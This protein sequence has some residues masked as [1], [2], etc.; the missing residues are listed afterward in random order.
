MSFHSVTINFD[1]KHG[2][3]KL[4]N[5]GHKKCVLVPMQR[6]MIVKCGRRFL[7][8][9]T[10]VDVFRISIVNTVT[11]FPFF[12]CILG[13]PKGI[14]STE[15]SITIQWTRPRHDGGSP[16]TGYVVEKRLL[17]DDKWTKATHA[18]IPDLNCR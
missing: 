9:M 8:F 3:S 18:I 1:V 17:S 10:S 11:L 16:I 4:H 12:Y 15:D 5:S 13:A 6:K 7:Y 14:D 2:P